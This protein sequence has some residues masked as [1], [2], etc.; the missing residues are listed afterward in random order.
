MS[1]WLYNSLGHA[2]TENV[3]VNIKLDI[4]FVHVSLSLVQSKHAASLAKLRQM[5]KTINFKL[6]NHINIII[7]IG[8]IRQQHNTEKSAKLLDFWHIVAKIEI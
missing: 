8:Y 1:L 6:N 7:T 3:R 2:L 5:A 4:N